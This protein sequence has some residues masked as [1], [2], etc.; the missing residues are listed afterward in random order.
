[1][2]SAFKVIGAVAPIKANATLIRFKIVISGPPSSVLSEFCKNSKHGWG[3]RKEIH[4]EGG[5]GRR[6]GYPRCESLSVKINFRQRPTQLQR[7]LNGLFAEVVPHQAV[8]KLAKSS[9][10][11]RFV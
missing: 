8:P 7:L 2:P 4:T 10:F 5:L 9:E 3:P 6:G 1:M 11:L